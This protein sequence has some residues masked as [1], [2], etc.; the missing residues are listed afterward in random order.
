MYPNFQSTGRRQPFSD[1]RPGLHYSAH[2]TND[3]Q[4]PVIDSTSETAAALRSLKRLLV[5]TVNTIVKTIGDILMWQHLDDFILTDITFWSA[6]PPAV[7]A[8]VLSYSYCDSKSLYPIFSFHQ[9][10]N[11]GELSWVHFDITIQYL[12]YNTP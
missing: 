9:L 5:G 6:Y 7:K 10:N 11:H 4:H 12:H 2:L 3:I 8:D 1:H